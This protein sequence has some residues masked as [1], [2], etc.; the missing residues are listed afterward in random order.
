MYSMGCFFSQ[1]KKYTICFVFIVAKGCVFCVVISICVQ[2]LF[3]IEGEN[4]LSYLS[5]FNS[6]IFMEIDSLRLISSNNRYGVLFYLWFTL[7][8]CYPSFLF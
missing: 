5:Y 7:W 8:C 2:Q 1:G 4:V 3:D 6:E